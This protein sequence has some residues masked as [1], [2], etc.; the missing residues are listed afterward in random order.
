MDLAAG[1]EPTPQLTSL[2]GIFISCHAVR[3]NA[4]SITSIRRWRSTLAHTVCVVQVR[5]FPCVGTGKGVKEVFDG[6]CTR[7]PLQPAL[8]SAIHL[9][10]ENSTQISP[11]FLG[12]LAE[13]PAFIWH[14]SLQAKRRSSTVWAETS[15][16]RFPCSTLQGHFRQTIWTQ[17]ALSVTSIGVGDPWICSPG[18]LSSVGW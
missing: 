10:F 12:M 16:T 1:R 3:Q 5:S 13:A 18:S 7:Q 14:L 15:P 8:E 6:L 2:C 11:D 4:T 9:S 17:D